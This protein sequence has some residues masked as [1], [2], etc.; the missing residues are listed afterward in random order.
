MSI[1]TVIGTLWSLLLL[2]I[3]SIQIHEYSFG[4]TLL[5]LILTVVGMLVMSVLGILLFSLVQELLSFLK[6]VIYE[7][8][9]R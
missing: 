2:I 8:S 7:L 4:K 5:S 9:L 3:G 6:A 1:L